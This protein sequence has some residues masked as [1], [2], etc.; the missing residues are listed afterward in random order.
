MPSDAEALKQMAAGLLYIHGK[1]FAHLN[2]NPYSVFIST[3]EPVRLMIAQFSSYVATT[4]TGTF[5]IG[6]YFKGSADVWMAPE[7]FE[8]FYYY[9]GYG[10][11]QPVDSFSIASDIWSLGCLFFY[12]L[13]RGV[14]PFGDDND[15]IPWKILM[16]KNPV[17]LEGKSFKEKISFFKI[18]IIEKF[19]F[20][21]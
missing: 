9:D 10:D 13:T 20:F 12:F 19:V 5:A 6:C 8:F 17:K 7:I 1:G 4:D 18:E 3:S 14:H 11:E 21:R 15:I 2:I 16:K